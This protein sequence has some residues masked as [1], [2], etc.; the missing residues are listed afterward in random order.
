MTEEQ[1]IN[2]LKRNYSFVYSMLPDYMWKWVHRN[3]L[4]R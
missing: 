1:F 3:Y 4:N 2:D